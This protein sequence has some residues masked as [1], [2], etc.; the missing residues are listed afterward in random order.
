MRAGSP[1]DRPVDAPARFAVGDAVRTRVLHPRGHTRLPRY[2]RGK[3]G[4]VADVHGAHVFPDANS[5][6][7]GEQP[8]WLYTVRFAGRE[9]WGDAAEDGL[10][11]AIEAWESYL[12]PA[13]T[14]TSRRSFWLT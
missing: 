11:V 2:A 10:T 9:L 4:E 14:L 8:Q 12:D 6:G 3:L 1:Y 13:G 7:D 5:A